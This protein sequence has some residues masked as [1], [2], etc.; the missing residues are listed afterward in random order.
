MLAAAD[1]P[2]TFEASAH[3]DR[4]E[5]RIAEPLKLAIRAAAPAGWRILPPPRSDE[6]SGWRVVGSHDE[7][8]RT[9]ERIV[10][11]RSLTLEGYAPGRQNIGPVEIRFQPP[12]GGLARSDNVEIKKLHTE[13][14]AVRVRSAL[15]LFELG[16]EL[17]PIQGAVAVPWTW[18]QWVLAALCLAIVAGCAAVAVRWA[19]RFHDAS[20]SGTG[21]PKSLARE[22]YTLREA[23]LTGR[24]SDADTVAAAAEI[25]RRYL[26]WQE[27]RSVVYRTTDDWAGRVRERGESTCAALVDLL[28][29]ADRVKFAH[30][31]PTLD[32]VR[33]CLEG[34]RQAINVQRGRS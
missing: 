12:A 33:Q 31:R 1:E 22:L 18:R 7:S 13:E 14:V 16:R 19:N 21:E 29:V 34:V 2:G 10:W 11:T 32:E 27:N 4:G 8:E 24:S 30:A 6:L 3:V 15:G 9:G 5:V 23:W 20:P 28:R 17:R 25:A 26:G